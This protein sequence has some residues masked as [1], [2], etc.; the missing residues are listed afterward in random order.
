MKWFQHHA[1]AH[2][3]EILRELLHKFGTDGIA[4]WWTTAELVSKVLK[5]VPVK[6]SKKYPLGYR[7][8]ARLEADPRIF[9]DALANKV[10]LDRIESVLKHCVRRKRF[11]FKV[12]DEAWVVEWPKLFAFKDNT[13]ADLCYK[14]S[15][16]LPSDFQVTSAGGVLGPQGDTN[17]D[18]SSE[19]GAGGRN[20]R[21]IA[22]WLKAASDGFSGMYEMPGRRGIMNMCRELEKQGVPTAEIVKAALNK[23]NATRDFFDVVNDL[24][25]LRSGGNDGHRGNGSGNGKTGEHALT[26]DDITRRFREK[27]DRREGAGK[28]EPR[29]GHAADAPQ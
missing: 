28:A 4:I 9:S 15:K 3:D 6:P 21:P 24:K 22:E 27:V 26:D 19:G 23:A 1:D 12:T 29:A 7:I 5:V 20:G 17:R 11:Y 18:S 13:T 25:Q 16:S 10:P 8:A 2:D 14:I